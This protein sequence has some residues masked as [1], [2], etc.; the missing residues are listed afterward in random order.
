MSAR[1]IDRLYAETRRRRLH[2]TLGLKVRRW[3]LG[4]ETPTLE[5]AAGA[6][7]DRSYYGMDSL[8][9]DEIEHAASRHLADLAKA[10]HRG[11]S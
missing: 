5:V 4:V 2:L 3:L 6:R 11:G 7:A 9:P 10:P 8:H 1:A